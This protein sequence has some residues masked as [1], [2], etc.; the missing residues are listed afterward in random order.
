MLEKNET[1]FSIVAANEVSH[2][3]SRALI[4]HDFP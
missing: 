1:T 4:M 2:I 3:F